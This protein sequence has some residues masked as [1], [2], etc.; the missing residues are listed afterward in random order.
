[1][2]DLPPHKRNVNTV[3]QNDAL[4][5]H[6]NVG[7]EAALV[8]GAF[9]ELGAGDSGIGHVIAALQRHGY[10]GWLVVEQD[11]FLFASDTL[12]TLRQS[13]RRNREFL[14]QLGI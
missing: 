6:L 7:M 12:D 2:N 9:V 11:R 1:M 3:F 10:R 13:Q 5:P 8:R 14:R 4:F